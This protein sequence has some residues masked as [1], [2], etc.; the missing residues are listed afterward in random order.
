ML[1]L[2]GNFSSDVSNSGKPATNFGR[3]STRENFGRNELE[4]HPHVG[5]RAATRELEGRPL[6]IARVWALQVGQ[7]LC[8]YDLRSRSGGSHFLP[9]TKTILQAVPRT[10]NCYGVLALPCFNQVRSLSVTRAR[11]RG[12]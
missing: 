5:V 2:H 4:C 12:G 3:L 10:V 9:P 6:P 1:D 11:L 8:E 7:H